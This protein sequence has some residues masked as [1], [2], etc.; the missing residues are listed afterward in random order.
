MNTCGRG[1]EGQLSRSGHCE[2]WKWKQ[3]LLLQGHLGGGQFIC[4]QPYFFLFLTFCSVFIYLFNDTGKF[5]F[6]KQRL[7]STLKM[8]D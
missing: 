7:Y 5:I 3:Y 1:G 8:F 4:L 6:Q 2:L